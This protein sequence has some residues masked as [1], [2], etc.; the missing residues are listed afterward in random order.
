VPGLA[1]L[2]SLTA[3][4]VYRKIGQKE[5]LWSNDAFS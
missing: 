4:V 3:K 1:L 5:P 2:I